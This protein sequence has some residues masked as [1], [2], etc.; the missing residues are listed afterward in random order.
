MNRHERRR[1]EAQCQH[2]NELWMGASDHERARRDK[3]IGPETRI[4][5]R[6]RGFGVGLV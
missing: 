6:P 2:T 5:G 1:A 4:S 3:A